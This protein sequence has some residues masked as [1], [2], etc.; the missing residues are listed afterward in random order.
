MQLACVYKRPRLVH[1]LACCSGKIGG[2]EA[3]KELVCWNPGDTVQT[4]VKL[5]KRV[6]CAEGSGSSMKG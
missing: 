4:Q 1:R 6:T 3:G 5:I 2:L